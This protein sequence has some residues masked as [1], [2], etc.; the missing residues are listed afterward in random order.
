MK[1]F[2]PLQEEKKLLTGASALLSRKRVEY[3]MLKQR[4]QQGCMN[5]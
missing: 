3:K 1:S 5:V 4:N 2:L